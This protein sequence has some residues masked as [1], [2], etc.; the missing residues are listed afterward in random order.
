MLE[1]RNLV[2]QRGKKVLLKGANARIEHGY[3]VGFVGRNGAGKTSLMQ[4]ITGQ[5][6]EDDGNVQ[7]DVKPD[8]MAYLEQSLPDARLS[9]LEFVKSGDRE[10]RIVQDRLDQA[11]AA[12]DGVAIANCHTQLQDIDGYT[13]DTRAAIIMH[14]LGFADADFTK[15]IGSFSGGWQ[16][17][18]QLAKVLLSRADLL[19]L[20][21]PTN[22]LDLEAIAW[23]EKWMLSQNASI[24]LISH[25]RDFLDNVCTHTLHLAQQKLKLYQGNY[26]AFIKQFELQLEIEAKQREGIERQRAH[27]QKFVDRFRYKATKARQAQS[28]MKAIEKLT[29]APGV[30]R[31]SPFHFSFRECDVLSSPILKIEGDAGYPEHPVLSAID[32]SFT[33]DDRIALL[34]VNG[35]GKSTLIKTLARDLALLK[36]DITAHAKLKIGHY[37][38]QQVKSLDFDSTPLAHMLKHNKGIAESEARRFLGGF[39]I[40]G[41]RVFDKVR[42]FSGGEKARLALALLIYKA[43]NV[44][45][46]DEPTNHLDIQMREALILALQSYQGAVIIVSHDRYFVNSVVDSLLLVSGGGVTQFKGNLDDYQRQVLDQPTPSTVVT[47]KPAKTNVKKAAAANPQQLKKLEQEIDK[48]TS[49]EQA[50]K[51]QLAEADLYQADSKEQL[52]AVQQDFER[53]TQALHQAEE[54]WLL[55][56]DS[57]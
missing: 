15:D 29:M 18:L 7:C 46:L 13:I 36:G 33:A 22:H 30:Q 43:P 27:M 6:Q 28:R 56:S 54:R 5:A 25:D 31:D 32:L 11:E 44:L 2:L 12:H 37:S 16:M 40:T 39:N 47:K 9:A 41:D 26:T 50:L 24:I 19:L 23:F 48:L 35:A 38:Q 53:T 8:R 55:L 51:Q 45:L 57:T 49:K 52:K 34:G 17:R 4:V 1:F 21:E 14:G 10:W 3:R 42:S 20:D